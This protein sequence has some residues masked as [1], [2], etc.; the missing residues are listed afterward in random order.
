MEHLLRDGG[1]H[2]EEEMR[3]GERDRGECDDGEV[4]S[5]GQSHREEE[6]MRE[7]VAAHR[8]SDELGEVEGKAEG[9]EEDRAQEPRVVPLPD[10]GPQQQAVV[11]EEVHAPSAD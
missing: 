11:V 1:G 10:A 7:A 4:R 9:V 3:S 6:G 5:T 2:G 8:E